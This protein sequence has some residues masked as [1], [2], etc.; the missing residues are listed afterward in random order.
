MVENYTNF[1]QVEKV[2]ITLNTACTL[3]PNSYHL[4]DKIFIL[5]AKFEC[6]HEMAT[7][8]SQEQRVGTLG[9][10]RR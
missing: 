7:E 5:L 3:R 4:A 1:D 10:G 6:L 9:A 2:K 8:G